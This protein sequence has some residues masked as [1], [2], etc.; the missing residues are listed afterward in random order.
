VGVTRD[1]SV[2]SLFLHWDGSAWTVVPG[3]AGM[4]GDRFFGGIAAISP[5][6]VWAVGAWHGTLAVRWNGLRWRVVTTPN[7]GTFANELI[8]ASAIPGTKQA[9]AVGYTSNVGE[10]DGTLIERSC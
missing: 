6:R 4:S 7:P 1:D 9:W 3:P 2:D 8:G 10:P 5:D